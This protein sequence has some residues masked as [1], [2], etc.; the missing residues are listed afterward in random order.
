[1][2]TPLWTRSREH[3]LDG[4]LVIRTLEKYAPEED[5]QF[6]VRGGRTQGSPLHG[7]V[8][9]SDDL[10][11]RQRSTP[12]HTMISRTPWWTVFLVMLA[13]SFSLAQ[14]ANQRANTL[15]KELRCPVCQG[16]PIA[17]SPS[18]FAKSM[19]DEL[20]DQISKGR[21]DDQIRTYF[22]TK[23]GQNI[24]LVPPKSGLSLIVWLGPIF[25]VVLG[26]AGL[27]SYLR[28]ASQAQ[29]VVARPE[30]LERVRQELAQKDG[31]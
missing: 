10:E 6:G 23:Y 26:G 21:T 5:S 2:R 25:M 7:R 28:R 20:R 19:M 16:V 4:V 17:E 15:G 1:M 29:A 13:F 18:E 12:F 3:V 27:W 22:I 11:V 14:D 24:L 31:P 8:G 30:S 9:R